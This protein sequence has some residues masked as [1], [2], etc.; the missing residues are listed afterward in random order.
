MNHG[1]LL[2]SNWYSSYKRNYEGERWPVRLLIRCFT[3]RKWSMGFLVVVLRIEIAL[4]ELGRGDFSI[5][6]DK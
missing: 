1:G 4:F 5:N 3:P 2:A 6:I